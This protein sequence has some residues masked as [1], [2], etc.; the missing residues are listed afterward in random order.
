ML[1][2]GYPCRVP[3]EEKM[4]REVI[5]IGVVG[6]GF[7]AK[8]HGPAFARVEGCRVVAVAGRDADKAATAGASL[9]GVKGF[10]GWREMLDGVDLDAITI[11]VPPVVQPEIV[12]EA[13]ARG[14]SV[15][16]EK[17]AAVDV[18]GAERMLHAV[19]QGRVTHAINF[20]FPEI[21][22][23]VAAKER[24]GAMASAQPLRNAA[25][26]WRVETYAHRHNLT[27]GWKRATADGGG[28]LNGFV[29]HS[30]Y[31]LEWLFGPVR[32]L[33][34]R[35]SPPGGNDD[36]RVEA[37]LDFDSGM[38][39]SLSVAIDCPFG[40][41][42]R[43]EVY[44]HDS[45]VIL[46][47]PGAD[48]VSGFKLTTHASTPL[49][50]APRP[51]ADFAGVTDGRIWATSQIAA[52]FVSH[53]R[54]GGLPTPNLGHALHVQRVLHAFRESHQSQRWT[55]APHETV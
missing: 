47:N 19:T 52:R 6:L 39:A 25:L 28:A 16:C 48:Y 27:E 55:E 50:N 26:T 36:S 41:G 9:G 31:Y 38:S 15:F 51:V 14:L 53:L 45:A 21:P 5:R 10:A 23:W 17:S 8:V 44:G 35:L 54:S 49:P 22:A 32:R 33:L 18:A 34:A 46:D 4:N 24:I 30:V 42:H 11:A 40:T 7:G 1:T 3:T 20:L 43:L 13:A 37:W 2:A 12:C 29:S